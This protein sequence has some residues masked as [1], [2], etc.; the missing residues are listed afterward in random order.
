MVLFSAVCQI[1]LEA[2][3]PNKVLEDDV[4]VASLLETRKMICEFLSGF[5][6]QNNSLLKLIHFQVWYRKMYCEKNLTGFKSLLSIL[7]NIFRAMIN[8]SYP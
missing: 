7:V 4:N 8:G 1:L 5:L 3:Q 2:C 6:E